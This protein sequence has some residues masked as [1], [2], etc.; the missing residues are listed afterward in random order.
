MSTQVHD[1][2]E[3][4][5]RWLSAGLDESSESYAGLI[6]ELQG[7]L[8]AFAAADLGETEMLAMRNQLA[9]MR[10]IAEAS[11][12]AEVERRFGRGRRQHTGVHAMMPEIETLELDDEHF[13]GTT[14]IGDFFLG[15]NS[16][17]H[18]GVVA[19]IFDEVLGRL[20]AG[21]DRQPSRTAYLKTDFRS[22]TPVNV[23]L[24]VRA[25][26]ERIEGR[27]RFLVGEIW[28]GEVLCAEAHALFVELK[29]GQP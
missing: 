6:G 12:V 25:R 15:V 9:S 1:A 27:K 3:A 21:L 16:A 10:A 23:P 2:K 8:D 24:T 20:S 7:F 5:L 26:V 29:H 14:R 11:R 13:L 4:I 19:L 18:G 22:I 28:H 17:A